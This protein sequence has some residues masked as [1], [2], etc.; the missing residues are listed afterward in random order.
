MTLLLTIL[1]VIVLLI[2]EKQLHKPKEAAVFAK[3]YVH[4]G[5]MWAK[6]TD[7]GEVLVGID[8]FTASII[9][10]VDNVKLPRY[11]KSLR[12][13]QSAFEI[14]HGGR[15]ITL[16]SPISGWV[17]EKNQMLSGNPALAATSPLQ[18]GW[19]VKVHPRRF[20]TEQTSLFTGK[21]VHYWQDMTKTHLVRFF[22]T[23][24]VFTAQDGGEIIKDLADSCSDI[25]WEA[26]TREF[27][28]SET[29]T[30]HAKEIL[31]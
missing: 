26:M 12:Q 18:E 23:S 4:P 20:A 30:K 16:V 27:F 5:H 31:Q 29:T 1:A 8:E 24:P 11:L 25:E 9:G 14:R 28:S 19:L 21:W 10:T 3:R 15:K 22:S 2:L 17:I 7:D 13:G 6:M